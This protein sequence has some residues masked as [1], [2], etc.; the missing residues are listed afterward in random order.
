MKEQT[1]N[2]EFNFYYNMLS[3]VQ[4]KSLLSMMKSFLGEKEKGKRISIAQYNKEL[5]KAEERINH[6]QFVT[7]ESL[8]KESEKW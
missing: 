2:K 6:G 1:I 3:E 8:R 4:K 5:E 7:Q